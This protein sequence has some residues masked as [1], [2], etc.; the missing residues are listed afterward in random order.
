[1]NGLNKITDDTPCPF[2]KVYYGVKMANVP[3]DYLLWCLDNLTSLRADVRAYIEDNKAAL[4]K[5]VE[6]KKF[7][8]KQNRKNERR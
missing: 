1:M 5:E 2:G 4:Q 8:N 3:A 6:N 7:Q